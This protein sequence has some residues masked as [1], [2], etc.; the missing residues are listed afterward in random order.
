MGAATAG[1][2]RTKTANK[3]GAQES[4]GVLFAIGLIVS[5]II[6][7]RIYRRRQA[8]RTLKWSMEYEIK[9]PK[10]LEML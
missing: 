6:I 5:I 1:R 10:V 8:L 2:E 4:G 3:G 7:P 9:Y